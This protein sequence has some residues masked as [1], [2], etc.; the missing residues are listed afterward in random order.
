MYVPSHCV[1]YLRLF[2]VLRL[3]FTTK[4]VTKALQICRRK[5]IVQNE[6]KPSEKRAFQFFTACSRLLSEVYGLLIRVYDGGGDCG[7][8][9]ACLECLDTLDGR[10]AGRAYLVLKLSRVLT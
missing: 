7:A 9:S 3:Y 6:K 8:E 2:A 10:A 5:G 1:Y 4:S